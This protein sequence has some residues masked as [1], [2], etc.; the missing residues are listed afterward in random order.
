MKLLLFFSSVC[1]ESIHA[2]EKRKALA[3]KRPSFLLQLLSH[4]TLMGKVQ[5]SPR[6]VSRSLP[7]GSYNVTGITLNQPALGQGSSPLTLA[8]SV[9]D[10]PII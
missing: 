9:K 7:T 4:N 5:D 2:K 1:K 8:V 10:A 6:S 3:D